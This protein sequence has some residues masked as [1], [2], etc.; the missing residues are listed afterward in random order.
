M[1][2]VRMLLKSG[3]RG[4]SKLLLGMWLIKMTRQKLKSLLSL[5]HKAPIGKCYSLENRVDIY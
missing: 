3:K 2:G 5:S 4:A 1:N